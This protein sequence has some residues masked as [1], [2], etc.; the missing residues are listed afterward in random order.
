[1]IRDRLV[2]RIDLAPVG[3][4]TAEEVQL[5]LLLGNGGTRAGKP[6]TAS[7]PTPGIF[8]YGDLEVQV[9]AS[10]F[11]LATLTETK[12]RSTKAYDLVLGDPRTDRAAPV[13]A[14]WS[15]VVEIRPAGAKPAKVTAQE[16]QLAVTVGDST[17]TL[18]HHRGEGSAKV[19]LTGKALVVLPGAAPVAGPAPVL[20]TGGRAL[21]IAG[22]DAAKPQAPWASFAAMVA[23]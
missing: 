12:I 13:S 1:M 20:P 6:Q 18:W 14:G 7:E 5:A 16:D 22:P 10:T 23:P 17:W 11:A 4:Q 21:V 15:A 8:R 19:A 9:H 3:D 2:G